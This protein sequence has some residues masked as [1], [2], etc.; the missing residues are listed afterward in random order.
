MDYFYDGW[1]HFLGLRIFFNVNVLMF[2]IVSDPLENIQMK[3][4]HNV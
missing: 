4:S 2:N 3:H 1:M